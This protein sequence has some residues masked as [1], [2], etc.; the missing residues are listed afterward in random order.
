MT[1][2]KSLSLQPLDKIKDITLLECLES[3]KIELFIDQIKDKKGGQD[4]IIQ[5]LRYVDTKQPI[6]T[7]DGC[8][9]AE[10][11]I[12]FGVKTPDKRNIGP[13]AKKTPDAKD[14]CDFTCGTKYSGTFG[15]L[16]QY[17]SDVAFPAAI[18]AFSRRSDIPENMPGSEHYPKCI[19]QKTI[20]SKLKP[21]AQAELEA[22]QK[23]GDWRFSMAVKMETVADKSGAIVNRPFIWKLNKPSLQKINGKM[24]ITKENIDVRSSD[25]HEKITRNSTFKIGF[26]FGPITRKPTKVMEKTIYQYYPSFNISEMTLVEQ[27]PPRN[28]RTVKRD[29]EE[30]KELYDRL[31]KSMGIVANQSDKK[32]DADDE[33]DDD[34]DES[35]CLPSDLLTEMSVH[36]PTS[37]GSV[38]ASMTSSETIRAQLAKLAG[39]ST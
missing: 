22:Y 4:K 14:E 24:I 12:L 33:H 25:I 31:T 15:K 16:I 37:T 10:A 29:D 5:V 34:R 1:E 39:D 19:Y 26:T 23:M 2:P 8:I 7:D 35:Q 3:K 17:Y 32:D 36:Q 6:F 28:G 9:D 27:A 13:Y 30:M 18:I 21:P 38:P 20:G 11:K